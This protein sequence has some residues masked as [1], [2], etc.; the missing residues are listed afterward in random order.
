MFQG[1]SANPLGDIIGMRNRLIHGYYD[2]DLDI[3][4]NFYDFLL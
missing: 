4:W 3:A 1:F 2:I